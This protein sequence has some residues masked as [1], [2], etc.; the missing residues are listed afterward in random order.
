MQEHLLEGDISLERLP[1]GSVLTTLAGTPVTVTSRKGASTFI[2]KRSY[3]WD[4]SHIRVV[5][6]TKVKVLLGYIP[7]Y[8]SQALKGS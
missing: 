8:A 6:G 7:N 5:S 3:E 4:C 1:D 2:K